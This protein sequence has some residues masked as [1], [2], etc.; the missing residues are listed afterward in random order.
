MGQ[1]I[2]CN[3]LVSYAIL[4]TDPFMPGIPPPDS[5]Q[6]DRRNTVSR[7]AVSAEAMSTLPYPALHTSNAVTPEFDGQG[8]LVN[9]FP[10]QSVFYNFFLQA[11]ARAQRAWVF[12]IQQEK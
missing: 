6:P 3:V 5:A 8:A 7:N 12:L 10:V 4:A 9:S 2:E 11:L 1:C